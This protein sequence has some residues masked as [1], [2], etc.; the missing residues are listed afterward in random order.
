MLCFSCALCIGPLKFPYPA[1]NRYIAI[2]AVH[3]AH[4]GKGYGKR[5]LAVVAA[6]ADAGKQECYLECSEK[7]VAVYKRA[8]YQVAWNN[9]LTAEGNSRSKLQIF[10]MVRK[11]QTG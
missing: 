3:P 9:D 5:L 10:G 7:N 8:G 2:L 6:W 1:S 4:Q 11:P